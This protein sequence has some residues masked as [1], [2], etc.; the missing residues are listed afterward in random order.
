MEAAVVA[1]G[2][3]I[4]ELRGTYRM[5][6]AGSNGLSI[7]T[8]NTTVIGFGNGKILMDNLNGSGVPQSSGNLNG[9]GVF[10]DVSLENIVID[11]VTVEWKTKP[12]GR[13]AGDGFRFLGYPSLTGASV[14]HLGVTK[15]WKA[16]RH[17]KFRNCQFSPGT[18]PFIL[19]TSSLK[20]PG[21]GQ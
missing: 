8:S 4:I 12:A 3:G 20:I 7:T 9:H 2:G 5:P 18:A 13:S 6:T 11:G 1:A 17:I 19:V 15:I 21:R 16:T 14:T 10:V